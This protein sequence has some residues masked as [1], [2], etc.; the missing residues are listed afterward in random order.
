MDEDKLIVRLRAIE[1]LHAGATTDGEKAAAEAAR[2]RIL[3][4][5]TRIVREDPPMEYRFT[6]SDAWSR[7]VFVALLRR[8][9][10]EP[11]RYRRQRHTTVMA[12]V[13]KRFVDETLWPEF[14]E[15]SSTLRS[16]ISEVTERVVHEVLHKDTSDAR[17]VAEDEPIAVADRGFA[18]SPPPPPP[19]ASKPP[20]SPP[21][22]P[23]K[24]PAPPLDPYAPCPCGSGKKY[25]WCCK[26]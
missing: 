19:P 16:Y 23:P 8:Y 9:G 15:F 22:P 12:K 2:E 10:I 4:R 14:Q 24:Q 25:K 20:V 21:V 26:G 18:P 13:S 1:A 17:S 7:K 11:Y 5:L 3:L 6:M